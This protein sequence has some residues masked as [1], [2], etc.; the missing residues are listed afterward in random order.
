[1]LTWINENAKWVIA[2]FAVGIA[3]GL[4][5]MDRTPE[6]SRQYPIGRVDV[7]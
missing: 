2:I 3:L 4:L 5:A 7:M 6:L 1:M